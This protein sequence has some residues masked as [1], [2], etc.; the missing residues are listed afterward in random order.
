MKEFEGVERRGKVN[1]RRR[2]GGKERDG[3]PVK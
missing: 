1:E 3:D 2:E